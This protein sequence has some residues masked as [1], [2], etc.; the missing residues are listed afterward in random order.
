MATAPAQ[1]PPRKRSWLE[2]H[3][4]LAIG[5]GVLLMLFIAAG[6][7]LGLFALMAHSDAA[8]LAMDRAQNHPV[9]IQ[10]LGQP[11]ERG[12][13]VMGQINLQNSSGEARLSIP[14]SGPKGKAC[15]FV[16]ATK[17]HGTWSFQKLTATLNSDSQEIDLLEKQK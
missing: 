9:L 15:L 8:T 12:F 3:W 1:F 10:N 11:I 17:N 5:V 2:R 14:V 13:P 4:V 16:Q 7:V 6:F